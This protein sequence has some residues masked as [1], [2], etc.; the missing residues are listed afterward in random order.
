MHSITELHPQSA[1]SAYLGRGV[2]MV[3]LAADARVEN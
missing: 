1:G 2:S 3:G